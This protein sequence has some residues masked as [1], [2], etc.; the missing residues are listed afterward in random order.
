MARVDNISVVRPYL[1]WIAAVAIVASAVVLLHEILLPFLAGMALAY[2]LDPLVHRLERIGVNRG[3]AAFA[4]ISL[5]ICAVLALV[6]FA[7]PILGKEIANLIEK[8][9]SYV[10]Q[11]RAFATHPSRPWLREIM[12]DAL[13]DLDRSSGELA[14]IGAGLLR[15]MWS[16]GRAMLHLFSLL[17]VT[18]I[19]TFYLILGWKRIVVT[20]DGLL[21]PEHRATVRALADEI[22]ETIAGFLR[23]QGTICLILALFYAAALKTIGLNHGLLIGFAS[24]IVSFIP[25][26][27]SLS[28]LVTSV[29]VV[30]LQFGANWGMIATVIGIFFVGQSLADHVLAPNLI[31]SRVKLNPVWIIFAV[32]AFG[33]LFGFVGLLIAVPLAA[34]IGVIVR[35]GLQ[36]YAASAPDPHRAQS[37]PSPTNRHH[38]LSG[39]G[40]VDGSSTGT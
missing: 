27:G 2:V 26:L 11:L 5:F 12:G 6:I 34:A 1:F 23:G 8:L 10:A 4:I 29:C 13:N 17:V 20:V 16:H 28:G 24:G 31:G 36:Q 3:V 22:D 30:V 32:F 18:P 37:S 39:S 7:A 40:S 21:P 38:D 19:V 35:F 25:Y 15:S 14:G 33:Y 9:P